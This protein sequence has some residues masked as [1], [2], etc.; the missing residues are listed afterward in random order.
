M[1]AIL[2]VEDNANNLELM[3]YLLDAVGHDITCAESGAEGIAA[4]VRIRPDLVILDIHL[5]DASGFQVLTSLR[6]HDAGACP[7]VAVTAN[8]MVGDRDSALAAGF[9]GYLSK[10][11]DPRQFAATI[12][13]MLPPTSRSGIEKH[14]PVDPA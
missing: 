12:G 7:V 8:A 13:A 14:S 3:R 4:A 9:D 2:I 10:P 6:R 5:P 1:A 11:I